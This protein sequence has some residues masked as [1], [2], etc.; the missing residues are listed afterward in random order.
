MKNNVIM[1]S[2]N[3]SINR[4]LY[5]SV[6]NGEVLV[7][8]PWYTTNYKIQQVIESKKEWI[9]KKLK[10]Y[11]GKKYQE[12]SLRP[13]QVL[14][15]TYELKISYKNISDIECSLD[16]KIIKFCLPKSYKK[17]DRELLTD[18]LMDKL[19]MKIAQ[20]EIENYMEKIRVLTG[21]APEDYSLMNMDN[22]IAKCTEDKKIIINP[23]IFK[24]KK[25]TIEYIIL[26]EYCHLKY[27][28]HSKYFYN[29]ISKYMPN[30][31]DFEIKNI[32]Y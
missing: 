14:G 32:K 10:E 5:I 30:Y 3:K 1:Y 7:Q 15:T 18:L 29:M 25:E 20:N 4:D 27:K 24:Y 17:M 2:V 28:N 8:A 16:N 23:R 11:E 6:Q 21:M 26:H 31:K 19:Y 22:C 12:I 9:I 13:I